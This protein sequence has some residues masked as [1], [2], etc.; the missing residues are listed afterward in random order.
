MRKGGR[1]P[2]QRTVVVSVDFRV[3]VVSP[4]G[5]TVV[6]LDV[7]P[8]VLVTTPLTVVVLLL[9]VSVETIGAGVVTGFVVVC[10]V[11]ELDDD[12]CAKVALVMSEMAIVAANKHLI[13][14]SSPGFG[15]ER[16][17]SSKSLSGVFGQ[18]PTAS[19]STQSLAIRMIVAPSVV[20]LNVA[21]TGSDDAAGQGD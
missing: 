5:A 9:L 1:R 4:D 7:E 19:E 13:I 14:S 10:V 3:A 15:L 12:D 8:L 17:R 18:F 11:V 2:D 16:D 6:P 20:T 21:A